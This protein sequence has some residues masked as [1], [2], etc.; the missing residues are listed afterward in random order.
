MVKSG[1]GWFAKTGTFPLQQPKPGR[2]THDIA[3]TDLGL[4]WAEEAIVGWW[5]AADLAAAITAATK[6]VAATSKSHGSA[7]AAGDGAAAGTSPSEHSRGHRRLPA[8]PGESTGRTRLAWVHGRIAA[9]HGGQVHVSTPDFAAWELH[10]PVPGQP[11]LVCEYGPGNVMVVSEV[12]LAQQGVHAALL[13]VVNL[14]A[15]HVV[16]QQALCLPGPANSP[17]ACAADHSLALKN[18]AG[19][20]LIMFATAA[21]VYCAQ[22]AA[23]LDGVLSFLQQGDLS[24]AWQL[25]RS[26]SPGKAV[27]G[28]QALCTHA[29]LA[30]AAEDDAWDHVWRQAASL[31]YVTPAVASAMVASAVLQAW[32]STGQRR[33]DDQPGA[34][35][36]TVPAAVERGAALEHAAQQ[37]LESLDAEDTPDWSA[38]GKPL[39]LPASALSVLQPVHSEA[40]TAA[41]LTQ[42]FDLLPA[43][44]QYALASSL[45]ACQPDTGIRLARAKLALARAHELAP[46]P[47]PAR[48]PRGESFSSPVHAEQAP[49]AA[50]DAS[51]RRRSTL[52]ALRSTL[53]GLQALA[54]GDGRSQKARAA[55]AALQ[56]QHGTS[57]GW[58]RVVWGTLS[59]RSVLPAAPSSTDAALQILQVCH[60]VRAQSEHTMALGSMHA[61]HLQTLLSLALEHWPAH[62]DITP[63]ARCM[64]IDIPAALP[65]Q[66]RDLLRA[67]AVPQYAPAR[68]S[69]L[70]ELLAEPTA[71]L[72]GS[73]AAASASAT[74][75][76][77][78]TA[79]DAGPVPLLG[80]PAVPTGVGMTGLPHWLQAVRVPPA[81][82]A[83]LQLHW[84]PASMT[85]GQLCTAWGVPGLAVA[86]CTPHLFAP[87]HTL[88][89]LIDIRD[90]GLTDAQ[91]LHAVRTRVVET[92]AQWPAASRPSHGDQLAALMDKPLVQALAYATC[93]RGLR[94]TDSKLFAQCT[95]LLLLA[96]APGEVSEA[97][98][99]GQHTWEFAESAQSLLEVLLTMRSPESPARSKCIARAYADLL[100][101]QGSAM[102]AVELLLHE[103]GD[104]KAACRI[105]AA[106]RT[107]SMEPGLWAAH[108]DQATLWDPMLQYCRGSQAKVAAVLQAGADAGVPLQLLTAL[109]DLLPADQA[110]Q[111]LLLDALQHV[112]TSAKAHVLVASGGV[113]ACQAGLRAECSSWFRAARAAVFSAASRPASVPQHYALDTPMSRP[114]ASPASIKSFA[115]TPMLAG[116]A[117]LF[118]LGST[119]LDQLDPEH[120]QAAAF[121]KSMSYGAY[122]LPGGDASVA[123][124]L[125][126]ALYRGSAD[127][128]HLLRSHHRP[129]GVP[130]SHT[131]SRWADRPG[132][133]SQSVATRSSRRSRSSSAVTLHQQPVLLSSCFARPECSELQRVRPDDVLVF[134]NGSRC[135]A[136]AA[137]L[138]SSAGGDESADGFL[139]GAASQRM[140]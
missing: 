8:L 25:V 116:V 81:L 51:G 107:A 68:L 28:M 21:G 103:L 93:V 48:A 53:A 54:T 126:S 96:L 32:R 80:T 115:S 87:V 119:T 49:G 1:T 122:H 52:Q 94:P 84:L 65:G 67:V 22:P 88:A 134:A 34:L 26:M 92:L 117:P 72:G 62:Q 101:Q 38:R 100:A 55:S 6:P 42:L 15:G 47:S 129:F 118:T 137:T 58:L 30:S 91:V 95:Q 86:A 23:P 85:A 108:E 104:V 39:L 121:V 77:A 89:T 24:T 17:W 18:T 124:G 114:A 14:D 19:F 76:T 33:S 138:A 45:I 61:E 20:P 113:A 139:P 106:A 46:T 111:P 13:S 12:L 78:A 27:Q 56:A 75:A 128:A 132:S 36:A 11:H 16:A 110:A 140:R 71:A 82:Q 136:R 109:F 41:Q 79:A 66:A 73:G 7:S 83:V 99:F 37:V 60:A 43:T 59:A 102:R 64:A 70:Q 98:K 97:C 69:T 133:D 127:T 90:A 123:T 105:V 2:C 5:P 35:P 112:A 130:V 44:C 131:V 4:A 50:A 120:D 40:D 31:L 10:V 9:V 29:M 63:L 3:W 125:F 74:A 57:A 135:P